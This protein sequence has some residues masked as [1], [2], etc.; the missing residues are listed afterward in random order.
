MPYKI[1]DLIGSRNLSEQD[2]VKTLEAAGLPVDKA[3]YSDEDITT[4]F[5]VIRSFFE[6]GRVK[7]Y[8]EAKELFVAQNPSKPTKN[9]ASKNGR[10]SQKKTPASSPSHQQESSIENTEEELLSV[11]EL[12]ALAKNRL[13]LNLTLGQ[14]SKIIEA[15]GLPDKDTYTRF[16]SEMFIT[17]CQKISE[18]DTFDIGSLIKDTT[19]GLEKGMIGLLDAVTQERAKEIPQALKQLYVKNAAQALIGEQEN[20]ETFFYTLKDSIVAGIEGESPLH[21]ITEVD[22]MPKQLPKSPPSL[23]QLPPTS[24]NGINYESNSKS[25][26]QK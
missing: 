25:N 4:K 5:D 11:T 23:N 13:D 12:L 21:S 8:E 20:I 16:E 19:S 6:E 17:I 2:V 7:N 26:E 14:A 18:D 10:K 3:E 1:D 15:G 9:Q 22:W 24:D